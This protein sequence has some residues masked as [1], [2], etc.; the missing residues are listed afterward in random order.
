MGNFLASLHQEHKDRQSRIR[1]A[2]IKAAPVMLPPS[3]PEVD[4]PTEE[5]EPSEKKIIGINK[6]N[7][8]SFDI[9]LNE[10]CRYYKVRRMDILSHRRLNNIC[11]PRQMLA[12][13]LYKMT[14]FT[15]HQ[16]APKMDR[17]PSSVAYAIKKVENE[18]A[19]HQSAIDHLE[20]IIATLLPRRGR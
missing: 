8:G 7:L 13:M 14:N 6:K 3:P 12:Y 17:D 9:I 19:L 1:R 20:E 16:I 5:A 10:I 15:T 11:G 18:L 4:P 2:A